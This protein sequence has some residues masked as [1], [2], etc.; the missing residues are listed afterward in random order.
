MVVI[1]TYVLYTVRCHVPRTY[2]YVRHILFQPTETISLDDSYEFRIDQTNS[3][4]LSAGTPICSLRMDQSRYG[5]SEGEALAM[6]INANY[7]DDGGGRML[8]SL[9]RYWLIDYPEVDFCAQGDQ[10]SAPAHDDPS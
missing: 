9:H 5:I 6:V 7:P 3:F 1:L 2:I 4:M 10:S 8:A